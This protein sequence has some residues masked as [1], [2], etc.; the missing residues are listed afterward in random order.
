M[1]PWKMADG[2]ELALG[3]HVSG[4]SDFASQLRA[5]VA[6]VRAG[7][8]PLVAAGPMPGGWEKLRLDDAW[9][10]NA[11]LHDFAKREGV[12]VLSGPELEPPF[13]QPSDDEPNDKGEYPV[14]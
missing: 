1:T 13:E 11:W 2:T 4:S 8:V 7:Y 5:E 9:I 10:L 3:G 12:E 14:Y 6:R